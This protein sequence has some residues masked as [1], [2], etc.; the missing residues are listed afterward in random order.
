MI[1]SGSRF[2]SAEPCSPRLHGFVQGRSGTSFAAFLIADKIAS[3]DHHTHRAT[4]GW[5]A[6]ATAVAAAA[7]GRLPEEGRGPPPTNLLG[8]GLWGSG[9]PGAQRSRAQR[10]EQAPQAQQAP[11]SELPSSA[12]CPQW[13]PPPSRW[14]EMK[15]SRRRCRPRA[16]LESRLLAWLPAAGSQPRYAA[17]G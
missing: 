11:R 1:K 6:A 13:R 4:R 14:A 12:A 16:G 2:S 8:R 9:A 10:R 3:L 5:A 17:A 7:L 15:A